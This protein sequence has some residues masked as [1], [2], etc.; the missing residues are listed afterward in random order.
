[1]PPPLR[2]LLGGF[3]SA[4]VLGQPSDSDRESHIGSHALALASWCQALR[5]GPSVLWGGGPRLGGGASAG[6]VRR[7]EVR[8]GRRAAAPLACGRPL[9]APGDRGQAAL[10]C[11]H[12]AHLDLQVGIHLMLNCQ[13]DLHPRPTHR[14]VWCSASKGATTDRGGNLVPF[15]GLHRGSCLWLTE[16]TGC[17][18]FGDRLDFKVVPTPPPPPPPSDACQSRQALTPSGGRHLP[19]VGRNLPLCHVT[20]LPGLVKFRLFGP[21]QARAQVS[22]ARECWRRDGF[23]SPESGG[24]DRKGSL[25]G[26]SRFYPLREFVTHTSLFDRPRPLPF[27]AELLLSENHFRPKWALKGNRRLRN[28]VAVM[29][30]VPEPLAV[31]YGPDP[32]SAPAPPSGWAPVGGACCFCCRHSSNWGGGLFS[33]PTQ[34]S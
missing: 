4:L 16:P 12:G 13:N 28:V 5:P 17:C 23:P 1:M 11:C 22:G 9:R 27:P 20:P 31:G 21:V 10:H 29:E 3:A 2:L 30:W 8:P 18:G 7:P 33:V 26:A 15:P 14:N 25:R 24:D 19:F 32:G 34:N 6:G